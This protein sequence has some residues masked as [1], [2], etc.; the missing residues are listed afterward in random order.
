MRKGFVRRV[1]DAKRPETRAARIKE[2]VGW[3]ARNMSREEMMVMA[4]EYRKNPDH[5]ARGVVSPKIDLLQHCE[6]LVGMYTKA[7]EEA[8]LLAKGHRDM[9]K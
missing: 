1:T 4:E 3:I 8:D 5:S 2:T 9:L 6:G 7:A